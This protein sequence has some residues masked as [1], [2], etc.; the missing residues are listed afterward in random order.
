MFLEAESMYYC[1]KVSV[2][3]T[4][5]YYIIYAIAESYSN[6]KIYCRFKAYFVSRGEG[7][8]LV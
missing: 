2:F 7:K 1:P 8:C 4:T 3:I 5:I 6:F